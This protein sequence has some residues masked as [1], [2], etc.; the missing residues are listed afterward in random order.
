MEY[1]RTDPVRVYAPPGANTTIPENLPQPGVRNPG[2]YK[3][4]CQQVTSI[5]KHCNEKS[6]ASR[7]RNYEATKRFCRFLADKYRLE[8]FRNV[9][10][11]HFR[12]YV[13][14]LKESGYS[15]NTIQS[16]LSGIRFFIRLSGSKNEVSLNKRMD[17][18]RREAGSENRAWLPEE[19]EKAKAIAERMGRNDVV[20]AIDFI[21]A[22]GLR[23]EEM[24]VTKV[25][26]L[27]SA[28]RTGQFVVPT[29]KGG[30]RRAILLNPSQSALIARYLDYAKTMGL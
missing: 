22:F 7:K 13:K 4:L 16:D 12:A 19:K 20:T 2:L 27:M 1:K 28:L 14:Y 17:L 26:Y 21:D 18:P 6:H 25:E 8:K 23:L 9:E 10:D 11:R 24:C 5:Y 29:G 30:Q 15:P 3:N